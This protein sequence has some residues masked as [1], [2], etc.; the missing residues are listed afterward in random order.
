MAVAAYRLVMLAKDPIK[1]QAARRVGCHVF[2]SQ[3]RLPYL[4]PD[5]L[6]RL[7]PILPVTEE[8]CWT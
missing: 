7:H 4:R 1:S 8:R 6:S 2:L 5:P 3:E